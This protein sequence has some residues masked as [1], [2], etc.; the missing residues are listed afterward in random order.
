[1]VLIFLF[2]FLL[3]STINDKLNFSKHFQVKLKNLND[4]INLSKF[5]ILLEIVNF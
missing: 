1:M 2:Y 5:N 3:F 4:Q